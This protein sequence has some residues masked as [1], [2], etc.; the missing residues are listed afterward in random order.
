MLTCWAISTELLGPRRSSFSGEGKARKVETS[1][2]GREESTGA[3]SW[4]G[5]TGSTVRSEPKLLTQNTNQSW[6]LRVWNSSYHSHALPHRAEPR[7]WLL[8]LKPELG[9]SHL[10]RTPRAFQDQV[11]PCHDMTGPRNDSR[12]MWAPTRTPQNWMEPRPKKHC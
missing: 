6:Q 1:A 3:G 2:G 7:H 11:G 9:T 10:P 8:A 4:M 5:G 12:G